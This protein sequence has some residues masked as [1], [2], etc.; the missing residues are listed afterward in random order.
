M[1]AMIKLSGVITKSNLYFSAPTTISTSNGWCSKKLQDLGFDCFVNCDNTY[2]SKSNMYTNCSKKET[3]EVQ[4]ITRDFTAMI[5]PVCN[6]E[7]KIIRD[8]NLF[9]WVGFGA[10]SL[11]RMFKRG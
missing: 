3:A 2:I 4:I 5:N 10:L 8:Y 11:Y 6:V 1:K 7:V 9:Q